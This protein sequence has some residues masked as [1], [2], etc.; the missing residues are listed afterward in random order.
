[1]PVPVLIDTDVGIDDAVAIALAMANPAL[2]VRALTAV[3][4]NVEVDQV[5]RNFGRLLNA[6]KPGRRPAVGKGLDQ[7]GANLIDRRKHVGKDGLGESDLVEAEC[8][9]SDFREV[10]Q[11]ALS[12]AEGELVISCLGPL[13][14]LAAI[15]RE[16]PDLLRSARHIY[17]SGGSV[18]LKEGDEPAEFNFHRDPVAASEILSSGLPMTIAPLDVSR[19]VSIDESNIAHLAASESPFGKTLARI[20]PYGIAHGRGPGKGRM[21]ISDALNIGAIIWP[22]LFLKTRMHLSVQTSGKETGK[23]KP[24]LKGDPAQRVD[25][26]TAVNAVDFVEKLLESLCQEEFIV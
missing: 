3:G 20:L 2:E 9:A 19:L 11:A 24:E 22:A 18:W 7:T 6:I 23:V 17:I 16:H 13:T 25:L 14:N 15:W 4:G 21:Y 8:P 12:Q 1:M 26:L 10:Y 5:V